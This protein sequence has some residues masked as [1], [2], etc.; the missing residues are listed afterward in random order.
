VG[1]A[2]SS[3]FKGRSSRFKCF[4]RCHDRLVTT[5]KDPLNP[6]RT[7]C[8]NLPL[9]RTIC[10]RRSCE[11]REITGFALA[12]GVHGDWACVICSDCCVPARSL[13]FP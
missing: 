2:P 11:W 6:T 13:F 10:G 1:L 4:R 8:A 9:E 7:D 3:I 12:C 5:W